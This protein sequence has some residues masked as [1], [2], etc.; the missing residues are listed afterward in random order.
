M[1]NKRKQLRSSQKNVTSTQDWKSKL[2]SIKADM[3]ENMSE[4]E[5]REYQRKQQDTIIDQQKLN[6]IKPEL[7]A[8]LAGYKHNSG[9]FINNF[10]RKRGF[11]L[12][13]EDK[14]HSFD[15][16]ISGIIP[17]IFDD[18]DFSMYMVNYLGK[19]EKFGVAYSPIN[20]GFIRK[21][22][23]FTH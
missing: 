2:D 19:L 10:F 12:Y 4:Q 15:F 17:N 22:K 16:D 8:F 1:S 11:K 13:E 23:I 6:A 3:F 18:V 5:N 7:Y 20:V 21:L 9:I 14:F